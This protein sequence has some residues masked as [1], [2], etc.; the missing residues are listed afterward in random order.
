[1][2][3]KTFIAKLI[4]K[5]SSFPAARKG[6]VAITFALA[7]IPI[8]L[9]AGGAIDYAHAIAIKV[10]LQ[11]AADATALALCQTAPT[12][13]NSQLQQSADSVF[14]GDFNRPETQSLS[15]NAASSSAAGTT[16]DLTISAST[17]MPTAF[18]GLIG[19]QQL[20]I[21]ATGTATLGSVKL[22]VALVLDNTGSMNT[23]DVAP[24][25][26]SALKTATQQF[27]QILQNAVANPGDIEVAIIP[28]NNGVN[29]GTQNANASWIDW[30]YY[31][32]SGGGGFGGH[33]TATYNN[34]SANPQGQ[35]YYDP[36][37]G[38]YN[39][40]TNNCANWQ[41]CWSQQPPTPNWIDPNVQNTSWNNGACTW[42]SCWAGS[43]AWSTNS[44][45]TN[46]GGWQGCLMD[47]NQ[48]NDVEN[49]APSKSSTATLFPAV[50]SPYCPEAMVTLTDNWSALNDEIN[51]MSASGTT[52]QTIGLAWGW[53]ALSTSAPLNAPAP[54]TGT[55]QVIVLMTDGLNTENRWTTDE[56]LID[57]RTQKVCKNIQAAGI[58]IYTI[59]VRVG[60]STVLQNCAA[61]SSRY[62]V[63]N[64]AAGLTNAFNTIATNLTKLRIA[65]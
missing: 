17:K 54:A 45:S 43:G 62:F 15:V 37:T 51:G 7:L 24:T 58:T 32:N 20:N 49:T 9:G 38:G 21:T 41:G 28:F 50:F 63:V 19:M 2:G 29:V 48:N 65:R 55:S 44:S 61:S 35:N 59:L 60:S 52:N 18:L 14:K 12:E 5:F 31:S 26:I 10:A 11:N 42:S 13:S 16:C 27:L 1:M 53:L 56:T 6:N 25:R 36:Y 33:N 23:T 4:R 34:Y 39:Q 46:T 47:R 8:I 57:A 22:Q 64:D 3:D 30:E 40:Y